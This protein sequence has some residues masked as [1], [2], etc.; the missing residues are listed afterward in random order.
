MEH[1]QPPLLIILLS[2]VLSEG[3]KTLRLVLSIFSISNHL[4]PYQSI[5]TYLT[6]RVNQTNCK[7]DNQSSTVCEV[8]SVKNPEIWPKKPTPQKDKEKNWRLA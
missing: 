8:S 1:L 7:L 6:L 2:C 4:N 5:S 3:R